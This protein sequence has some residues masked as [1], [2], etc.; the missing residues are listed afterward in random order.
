MIDQCRRAVGWCGTEARRLGVDPTRIILSGSSAGGHL[1]AMVLTQRS[2]VAAAI[3][4]SG[5][6]DLEPLIGTYINV[7]V[8]IDQVVARLCSP[9][10]LQPARTIP[11]V[12]ATGAIE[13]GE[14]QRQ[15]D[16]FAERWRELGCPV[17]RVIVPGRNHF[18]VPS[19]L[20]LAE[21]AVGRAALAFEGRPQ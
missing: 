1:A 14:F 18:D 12:V 10:R 17:S 20:G 7:A 6:F 9:I 3:L 2:P 4:F 16:Q 21:S 19:E 15:S 13:S 11:I 5:V 8:G